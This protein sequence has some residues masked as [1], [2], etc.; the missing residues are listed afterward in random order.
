MR[1]I[2]RKQL[3]RAAAAVIF[4][5]AMAC[6]VLVWLNW[7]RPIDW[8]RTVDNVEKATDTFEHVTTG[9]AFI[10]AGIWAYHRYVKTREDK[11]RLE[12][13]ISAEP[14]PFGGAQYML[15]TLQIRNTGVCDVDISQKGT[16][17]EVS[18]MTRGSANG[19]AAPAAWA[20][21]PVYEVFENH[22]WIEPGETITD[23]VLVDTPPDEQLIL[24]LDFRLYSQKNHVRWQA[25]AI[26]PTPEIADGAESPRRRRRKIH[27]SK[28][29]GA[30]NAH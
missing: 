22:Q 12:P 3:T 25:V 20:A 10:V 8:D 14:V 7:N 13:S 24:K 16:G 1:H 23:Q 9:I 5:V 4:G 26:V 28:K 6:V 2:S 11:P 18:V 19:N 29:A 30:E 15:V 21:P 27:V 17:L